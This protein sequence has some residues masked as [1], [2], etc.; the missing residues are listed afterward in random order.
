MAGH[1]TETTDWQGAGWAFAVWTAHFTALWG[2]SSA[3][4]GDPA[5]RWIALAATVV[6]LAA[7]I[8]L[9]RL[10]AARRARGAGRH[11]TPLA[12]GM[13]GVAVLFGA[14]PALVG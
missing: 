8:W 5:A 1:Y 2:A 10:R 6:A 9:W 4:P 14:L 13:A 3:F 11:V 7:L 12:I